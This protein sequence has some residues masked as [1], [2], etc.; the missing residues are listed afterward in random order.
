MFS[1]QYSTAV[2]GL[3][4]ASKDSEGFLS[5]LTVKVNAGSRYSGPKDGISH[6]L[7]RFNFQNTSAKSALRFAREAE[8][9]GGIYSSKVTR[10]SIIL[11]AQ[12]QRQDLPYFVNSFADIIGS[13]QFKLHEFNEAV[14]PA[15]K[16]DN[17]VASSSL[18]FQAL[19]TLNSLIY[20][21]G[22]AKPLYYDGV[23]KISVNDISEF[24]SKVYTKSNIEI[25]GSGIDEASLNKYVT[26]SSFF[27]LPEGTKFTDALSVS[28]VLESS[29]SRSTLGNIAAVG[30]AVSPAEFAKY[31]IL[32]TYLNATFPEAT[33]QVCKYTDSGLFSVSV[34]NA[35]AAVV[36]KSI[37]S[38][39]SS[40]KSG[41][42]VSEY[43]ALSKTVSSIAA[44]AEG[45]EVAGNYSASEVSVNDLA[46]VAIGNTSVLPHADEL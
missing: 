10:D 9:L 2:K 27:D 3:K 24:A 25:I 20:R 8:L 16:H 34:S 28:P 22:L 37:K 1:R 17:K 12:F 38:I 40:L 26:D 13:T 30:T 39:V 43:V 46:Y 21:N 32:A 5:K 42:N 33:A 45:A 35:D 18:Q 4:V 41:V 36:S 44:E 6:L 15:A 23:T 19:E 11:S 7:S 29:R 31:E 14:L